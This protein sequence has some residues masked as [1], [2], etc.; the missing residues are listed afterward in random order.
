MILASAAPDSLGPFGGIFI[1]A[2]FAVFI[3]VVA[4][5][6]KEEN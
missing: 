4:Y 2:A 5:G 3:A 1:L 6:W